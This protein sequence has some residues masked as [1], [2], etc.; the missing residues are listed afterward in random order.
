MGFVT[1]NS[2]STMRLHLHTESLS[3]VF[4]I[5]AMDASFNAVRVALSCSVENR[6][7]LY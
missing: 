7:F 1:G 6:Q 3:N 2:V 5:A 4:R